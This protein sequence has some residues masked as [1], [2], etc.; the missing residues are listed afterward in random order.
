M[1]SRYLNIFPKVKETVVTQMFAL[2]SPKTMAMALPMMGR[3]AKK[4]IQAPYWD[5]RR[6][7]RSSLSGLTCRYF[8][9]QSNRPNVP[10]K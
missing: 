4:P 2:T 1:I 9:I 3:K 7:A 6:C 5:I 10:M 8:S